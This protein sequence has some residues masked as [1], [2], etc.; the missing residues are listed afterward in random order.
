M[1]RLL[2]GLVLLCLLPSCV[3]ANPD[4][5][6]SFS[7]PTI[8][9]LA[10]S[11]TATESQVV[12][13]RPPSMTATQLPT[14]T[15]T[16][17]PLPSS[18]QEWPVIPIVPSRMIEIHRLGIE[19]GNNPLAFSKIGD[20]EISANWFFIAFDNG[21]QCYDL[22]PY[23]DLQIVIDAFTGSFARQSLAAGPGFSTLHVLDPM[24][25]DY[26]SCENGETP[27]EC[28]LRMHQPSFAILSMGTSQA[29]RVEEFETDMR[30]IIHIL[31]D[32]GVVPILS[33]KGDNLEGDHSINKI[34]VELAQE[35]QVPLWNFWLAIQPLPRHGLQLDLEHLTWAPTDLDDPQAMSYAWPWRN[36]TAL[37][38]LEAVWNAV[39]V[40][41]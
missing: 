3:E 25:A 31:L 34:I 14:P 37:Q 29:W 11:P 30:E 40:R 36:L 17:T 10:H 23:T 9:A 19:A 24:T 5:G 7:T 2:P 41:P 28:E 4:I 27:L 18:W 38:A 15:L 32:H 6:N 39:R 8:S 1:K 35:Y 22:G 33:T 26:A 16:P 20:G 13:L 12:S 21:P